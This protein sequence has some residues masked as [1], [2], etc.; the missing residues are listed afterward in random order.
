MLADKD[1]IFTN[2]FGEH[3]WRLA[4][5]RRRGDWDHTRDLIDKGR[6][7]IVE[8]VPSRD[9]SEAA[10]KAESRQEAKKIAEKSDLATKADLER[11]YVALCRK[12]YDEGL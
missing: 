4:A 5:A 9:A 11:F 6:D 1:R 12:L 10:A 2:L 8:Q 3:D 7:W